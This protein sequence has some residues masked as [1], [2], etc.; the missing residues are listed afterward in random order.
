MSLSSFAVAFYVVDIKTPDLNLGVGCTET[1][2]S[3]AISIG[4]FLFFHILLERDWALCIS[5]LVKIDAFEGYFFGQNL[6]T[7]NVQ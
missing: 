1:P 2:I 3:E 7:V 5:N 6:C 4:I